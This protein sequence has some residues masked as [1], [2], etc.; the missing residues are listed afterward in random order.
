MKPPAFFSQEFTHSPKNSSLRARKLTPKNMAAGK[1]FSTIIMKSAPILILCLVLG[2]SRVFGT[3][4]GCIVLDEKPS[5]RPWKEELLLQKKN[6]LENP[7]LESFLGLLEFYLGETGHHEKSRALLHF[8]I[9]FSTN[10]ITVSLPLTWALEVTPKNHIH[11]F[12]K[13][14][15]GTVKI[16]LFYDSLN[17]PSRVCMEKVFANSCKNFEKRFRITKKGWETLGSKRV[18]SATLEPKNK[19]DIYIKFFTVS[20]RDYT[21]NC[22]FLSKKAKISRESLAILEEILLRSTGQVSPEKDDG[23]EIDDSPL[24]IQVIKE[25][26]NDELFK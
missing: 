8:K 18:L 22:L 21:H 10:F 23:M 20:D 24:K 7:T 14:K 26:I 4:P 13:G 11:I 15:E 16:I 5:T 17:C 3:N 1:F 19:K 2:P 12:K 25:R 6:F 9:G